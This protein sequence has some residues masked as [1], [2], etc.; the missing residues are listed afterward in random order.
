MPLTEKGH[1]IMNAMQQQYGSEKG[2]AVFYAS[3]N[4]GK[5]SGVDS[6]SSVFQAYDPY[7]LHGGLP[8]D[9]IP[10]PAGQEAEKI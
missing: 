9:T 4:A 1:E 6:L 10:D 8:L 5:I 7:V 3:R 2:E